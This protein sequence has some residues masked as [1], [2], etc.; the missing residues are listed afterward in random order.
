MVIA[1]R[2]HH[3]TWVGRET[4][5]LPCTVYFEDAEWKALVG[6]IKQTPVV[7]DNPPT[8]REAMIM[9]ASLGGFLNRKSDGNPGAQTLWRGLQRLDDITKAYIAFFIRPQNSSPSV[10]SNTYG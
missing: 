2:I 10:S 5:D 1:W 6:F 4:P 8:L 7:P 3:L 9:V